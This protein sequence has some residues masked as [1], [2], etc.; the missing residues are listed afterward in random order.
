MWDELVVSRVE[1]DGGELVF[2]SRSQCG[3]FGV[4]GTLVDAG[5]DDTDLRR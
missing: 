4:A 3:E 5:P 2:D 1:A